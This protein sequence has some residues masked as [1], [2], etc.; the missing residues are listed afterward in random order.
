MSHEGEV[1]RD[2]KKIKVRRTKTK[3]FQVSNAVE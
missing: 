3:E 1:A 2:R